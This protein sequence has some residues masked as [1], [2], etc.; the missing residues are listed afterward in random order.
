[1][2]MRAISMGLVLCFLASGEVCAETTVILQGGAGFL[3]DLIPASRYNYLD[4]GWKTGFNAGVG[5]EIFL[6]RWLAIAPGFELS[7]YPFD[8]YP[9]GGIG[10]PEIHVVEAVGK[11]TD[12]YRFYVEGRLFALHGGRISPYFSTG[13][14]YAIERIGDIRVTTYDLLAGRYRTLDRVYGNHDYFVHT[15]ALGARVRVTESLALDAVG[16]LFTNY[17][18][19]CHESASLG[20][21]YRF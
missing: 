4:V 15:I 16:R 11:A 2:S 9:Y 8:R 14:G 20:V 13:I 7:R 6:S 18:D 17:A 10:I 3:F 12:I 19:R 5:V 21:A 1:M